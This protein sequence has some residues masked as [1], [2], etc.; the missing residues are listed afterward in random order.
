MKRLFKPSYFVTTIQLYKNKDK[1]YKN[2]ISM[3]DLET[4]VK[5]EKV[6]KTV[7][8]KINIPEKY[9]EITYDEAITEEKFL[10]G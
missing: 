9:I 10:N 8:I 3:V 5:H 1:V 2:T 7:H 4:V 6:V